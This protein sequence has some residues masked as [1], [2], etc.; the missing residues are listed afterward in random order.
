MSDLRK[1]WEEEVA[2]SEFR[3]LSDAQVSLVTVAID[4]RES[5]S[6]ELAALRTA[7]SQMREAL[8][9]IHE[10]AARQ[11]A[12]PRDHDN[13][14][15]A[16]TDIATVAEL[17]LATP[18]TDWLTAH[19]SGVRDPLEREIKAVIDT[20][21]D[22]EEEQ[23]LAEVVKEVYENGED[24]WGHAIDEL[25]KRQK[26]E[27]RA[28]EAERQVAALRAALEGVSCR[29]SKAIDTRCPECG[30][31]LRPVENNSLLND[32]QFDA[33]K[34]GDW[35]CKSCKSDK[36]TSGFEYYWSNELKPVVYQECDRCATLRDTAATAARYDAG[37]RARVLQDAMDE[38][39]AVFG[40]P[41]TIAPIVRM[42]E[43]ARKEAEGA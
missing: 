31:D 19:D 17:A 12:E 22:V 43:A 36:A 29:C 3:Y 32:Y 38:L 41:D 20:Y 23:T 30:D 24:G 25:G 27:H 33:V 10:G 14:Q 39:G 13:D 18:A 40:E 7:N 34:A 42:W 4:Q 1:A 26:E 5:D 11:L 8:A 2:H 16:L 15:Y 6:T 28:E 9:R 35:F 37:V 21:G